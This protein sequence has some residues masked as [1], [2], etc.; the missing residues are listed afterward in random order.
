M[1]YKQI[2]FFLSFCCFFVSHLEAATDESTSAGLETN[3]NSSSINEP[4]NDSLPLV[5]SIPGFKV[6]GITMSQQEHFGN[7]E[8]LMKRHNIP[9]HCIVYNSNDHPLQEV[10]NLLADQYSIAITRVIP[11]IDWVIKNEQKRRQ[12]KKLPP[13]KDVVLI[14]YSQGSVITMDFLGRLFTYRKE[15]EELQEFFGTEFTALLNDPVFKEVLITVDIFRLIENVTNQRK[16]LLKDPDFKMLHT[17][18]YYEMLKQYTEFID[19]LIDPK[20]AYP[21]VT[22]FET[23]ESNK[24]PKKYVKF[25]QYALNNRD[26]IEERLQKISFIKNHSMFLPLKG[27]DFR[28][29]SISGSIFGSP[30]ANFGYDILYTF[31]I[32]QNV[33]QGFNQIKDTR[34]G[35]THHIN[36]VSAL[37]EIS[38]E[39]DYPLNKENCLFI[40]GANEE[41]GDGLVNQSSAHLSDHRYVEI[42]LSKYQDIPEGEKIYIKKESL[43]KQRVIGL[44]LDHFPKKLFFGLGP[45]VKLGSAYITDETH[46]TFPYLINFINKNF[47]E[48]D[49]LAADNPTDLQQFMVQFTFGQIK[50][51]LTGK[52]PNAYLPG[53]TLLNDLIKKLNIKIDIKN[54]SGD[55][56]LQGKYFNADNFTYVFLG[57]YEDRVDT[58]KEIIIMDFIIRARGFK[59]MTV[60]L[61]VKAGKNVFVRILNSRHNSTDIED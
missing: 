57:A 13:V 16:Y 23:P 10:A 5:L 41:D 50:T 56:W 43:P 38:E 54:K 61:P 19:Y 37:I 26:N 22:H 58:S 3:L 34:L 44:P 60:T 29:F 52:N 18:A 30:Q 49:K 39:G 27:I 8:E 9:Y 11:D 15:Y 31:P 7:L 47:D 33:V 14:G 59:P 51:E 48:I 20:T 40:V 28:F 24:Y 4:N 45:T 21:K 32:T 6:P 1:F 35:S 53:S 12:D 55:I 25:H 42:D 2:V 36:T 17:R 46:P